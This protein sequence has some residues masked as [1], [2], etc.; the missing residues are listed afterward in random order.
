MTSNVSL[1]NCEPISPRGV[2]LKVSVGEALDRLSILNIKRERITDVSKL[3]TIN[4]EIEMLRDVFPHSMMR[5]FNEL[6]NVNATLWNVED[7]LRI[8]ENKKEFDNAFTMLA[9]SVYK[10]NDK[11]F[12]IKNKINDKFERTFTEQKQHPETKEKQKIA[13]F[14]HLGLGDL[15]CILGGIRVFCDKYEVFLFTKISNS[16]KMEFFLRD[17]PDF[18]VIPF[19][20]YNY[21]GGSNIVIKTITDL[22]IP[23]IMLLGQ[24]KTGEH[25]LSPDFPSVFYKDLGLP[26]GVGIDLFFY[27][28]DLHEENKTYEQVVK[29][30]GTE[31]YVVVHDSPGRLDIDEENLPKGVAVFY[32]GR[33]EGNDVDICYSHKLLERAQEVHCVDS[34]FMWFVGLSKLK[35]K[36][37]FHIRS[38]NGTSDTLRY[39]FGEREAS[40][41]NIV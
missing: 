17:V 39:Y 12:I 36:K 28:R 5:E 13:I 41:W 15:L 16:T 6:T 24:H 32:I 33:E 26:R 2:S 14:P 25:I 8:K 34:S 30:L 7:L 1:Q 37:V 18:H 4:E 9:R 22:G 19:D 10:M 31:Q 35:T 20:E 38:R 29:K 40:T 23:Q 3:E 27:V 11:R 21:D